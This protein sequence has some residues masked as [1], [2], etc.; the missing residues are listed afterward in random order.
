M[1]TITTLGC[2]SAL[3]LAAWACGGSTRG[4]P[5]TTNETSTVASDLTTFE[6]ASTAAQGAV[7]S[8]EQNVGRDD[9]T[10]VM[11]RSVHAA[12]DAQMRPLVAQMILM[13][14]E[15]DDT[16]VAHGG[17]SSADIAC[18]AAAM[19]AE[20]DHHRAIACTYAEVTR[21]RGE[22]VRHARAM[23]SFGSHIS[24][25]SGEMQ[26]GIDDGTWTWGAMMAG[27]GATHADAGTMI[28]Q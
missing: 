14:R 11:C 19:M 10:V 12:Y 18:V 26:R 25:R 4:E 23:L 24:E 9:L 13:A 8:Y 3:A 6:D 1:K 2:A 22:A 21:D 5:G 20:L 17:L 27:C 28:G 16:I 7:T 15:M